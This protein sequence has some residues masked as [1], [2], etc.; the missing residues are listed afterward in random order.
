VLLTSACS[1]FLGSDKAAQ[2]IRP[3]VFTEMPVD[4]NCRTEASIG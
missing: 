1:T 2:A 3:D 4:W